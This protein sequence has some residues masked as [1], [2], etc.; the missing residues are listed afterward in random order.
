MAAEPKPKRFSFGGTEGYLVFRFGWVHCMPNARTGRLPHPLQCVPWQVGSTPVAPW[1]GEARRLIAEMERS[2]A[3][4]NLE[5][6][7]QNLSALD[8][9][10]DRLDHRAEQLSDLA[11]RARAIADRHEPSAGDREL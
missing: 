8:Q 1:V 11:A 9:V 7:S 4:G 5:N 6:V 10:A 3:T 2:Q